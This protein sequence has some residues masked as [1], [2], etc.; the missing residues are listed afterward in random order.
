[1][2][3]KSFKIASSAMAEPPAAVSSAYRAF[4]LTHVDTWRMHIL[5]HMGA[6]GL[7]NSVDQVVEGLRALSRKIPGKSS[8]TKPETSEP[9]IVFS[10][11]GASDVTGT[12]GQE[13]TTDS[14]RVA[15]E[16]ANRT[17]IEVLFSR[18]IDNFLTYLSD[19]LGEIFIQQPALLRS[20]EQVV[21]Q[22]VLAHQSLDEFIR[23]AADRKVTSLSYS[24][25]GEISDY[26]QRRA[27]LMLVQNQD[28]WPQL[29]DSVAIR[30]LLV[31]NRGI[32]DQRFLAG[33]KKSRAMVGTPLELDQARA[34]E[35]LDQ[36]YAVALDL[37]R[38]A[39]NKFRLPTVPTDHRSWWNPLPVLGSGVI[40]IAHIG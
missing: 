6:V 9:G 22:D 35:L 25:I 14:F 38:R 16:Q 17:F 10:W 8:T 3:T 26:F 11:K 28:H 20:Q 40:E 37:D 29:V 32:V 31:H 39:V 21:M 7:A 36:V 15:F 13:I 5:S 23:W 18:S 1:M 4:L 27:G 12:P 33:T 24:G 2:V 30:N 34:F 19:L